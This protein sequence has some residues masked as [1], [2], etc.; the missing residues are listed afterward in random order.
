V[1]GLTAEGKVY[2]YIA[3]NQADNVKKFNK[4]EPSWNEQMRLRMISPGQ[5]MYGGSYKANGKL[6][7]AWQIPY[8]L[9]PSE[10][11][12]I[13]PRGGRG[14]RGG[15]Y[16]C[17]GVSGRPSF[18]YDANPCAPAHS[19]QQ[20]REL[21][22]LDYNYLLAT[23]W[24][25]NWLKSARDN[26]VKGGAPSKHRILRHNKKL[27]LSSLLNSRYCC[28]DLSIKLRFLQLPRAPEFQS[29]RL[30]EYQVG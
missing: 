7:Y 26:T 22:P 8:L 24:S 5:H 19:T 20:P 27:N 21:Q 6:Y 30:P 29:L 23:L 1:R 28:L 15:S 16:G 12:T 2:L 10:Q 11:W 18:G 14:C 4:W 9:Y 25:R 17:Y 3:P 13:T